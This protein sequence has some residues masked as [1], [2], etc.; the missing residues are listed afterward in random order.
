MNIGK[1]Q[2]RFQRSQDLERFDKLVKSMDSDEFEFFD[3]KEF[4]CLEP[5]VFQHFLALRVHEAYG[6]LGEFLNRME[7]YGALGYLANGN[8]VMRIFCM[9][10]VAM[11]YTHAHLLC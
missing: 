7:L 5:K 3:A 1:N 6:A 10:E 2:K 9:N 11:K 4:E 8:V